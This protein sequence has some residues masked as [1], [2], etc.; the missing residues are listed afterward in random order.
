[1]P[2]FT[3]KIIMI[4]LLLQETLLIK[5]ICILISQGYNSNL[6]LSCTG[7]WFLIGNLVL[8]NSKLVVISFFY[9]NYQKPHFGGHFGQTF[10]KTEFPK[11]WFCLEIFTNKHHFLAIMNS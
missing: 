11:I 10:P 4:N 1:M 9:K 3:Q 8:F 6:R 2:A 5:Q 7:N